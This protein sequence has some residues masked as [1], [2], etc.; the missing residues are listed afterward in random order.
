MKKLTIIA[1][2]VIP[3]ASLLGC[4]TAETAKPTAQAE[5]QKV[6]EAS[7]AEAAQT[8]DSQKSATQPGIGKRGLKLP[9]AA[10]AG[11]GK[12]TDKARNQCING[13]DDNGEPC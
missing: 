4:A 8:A 6:V 1:L 13:I 9:A 12:S 5:T 7:Q 2:C 10:N 11:T 3:F